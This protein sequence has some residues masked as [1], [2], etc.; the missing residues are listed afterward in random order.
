MNESLLE[1]GKGIVVMG[2]WSMA[3]SV[4][5]GEILLVDSAYPMTQIRVG[6]V[7]LVSNPE[8]DFQMVHRVIGHKNL[9]EKQ[10]SFPFSLKGDRNSVED[11]L[12]SDWK[13]EGVVT[14]KY[15]HGRWTPIRFKRLFWLLSIWRLFPGQR[16]PS[17]M[18]RSRVQQKLTR[19]FRHG[20]LSLP[21]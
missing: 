15:K 14:R 10:T 9:S 12:S 20:R 7:V 1:H 17:W 18:S 19:I 5:P 8:R 16:L 11:D 2:G 6:D 13:Y 3:P 4:K 21:Q